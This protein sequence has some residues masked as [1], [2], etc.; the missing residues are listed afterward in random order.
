[1][2]NTTSQSPEETPPS[3][4]PAPAAGAVTATPMHANT[5]SAV[6]GTSVASSSTATGQSQ[7][8]IHPTPVAT[9]SIQRRGTKRG[10]AGEHE[11]EMSHDDREF[12]WVMSTA[13]HAADGAAASDAH[14]AAAPDAAAPDTHTAAAPDAAAAAPDAAAVAAE[15]APRVTAAE[16]DALAAEIGL[17]TQ[18]SYHP[19]PPAPPA[20]EVTDLNARRQRGWGPFNTSSDG[21]TS[22]GSA[23]SD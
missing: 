15:A 10:L 12:Q 22:S 7:V 23:N 8:H 19:G 5:T 9:G 18:Q 3:P 6:T 14:T 16:L 13:E 1:M 17:D 21:S 4:L 2:D 11:V 20:Q